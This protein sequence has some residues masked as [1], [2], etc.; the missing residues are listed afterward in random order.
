MPIMSLDGVL[1]G[2]DNDL[3]DKLDL[4][5]QQAVS[6]DDAVIYAFGQHWVDASK[7]GVLV[8]L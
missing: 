2:D 7:E 1:P 5:V 4:F 8:E 6:D 3:N